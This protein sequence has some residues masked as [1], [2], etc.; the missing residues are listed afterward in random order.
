MLERRVPSEDLRREPKHGPSLV[1]KNKLPHGIPQGA[2]ISDLIAN[3]YLLEFDKV[4]ANY[5]QAQ[6]GRYMRYSDDILLILPGGSAE[7]RAAIDFTTTEM[8]K[9]GPELRIKEPRPALPSFSAPW[10]GFG[11]ST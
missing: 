8:R 9:H 11:S 10:E 4:M 7:A 6:G 1:Q 3:F 5:A 2:P